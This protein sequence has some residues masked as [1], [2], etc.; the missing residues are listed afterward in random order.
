M[1]FPIPSIR[2][3]IETIQYWKTWRNEQ[4]KQFY[5][6]AWHNVNLKL[7]YKTL[8]EYYSDLEEY[9]FSY[10]QPDGNRLKMPLYVDK[11]WDQITRSTLEMKFENKTQIFNPANSQTEFWNFYNKLKNNQL[12]DSKIFRL[13]DIQTR[14]NGVCLHFELGSFEHSVMCQYILEHEI[15]TLLAQD[16]TPSFDK[17]KLRNEVA[18]DYNKI[19]YFFKNNV[20]RI[21]LNN[22]ILLK[23]DSKNYLP[24]VQKRSTISM[25]QQCLFDQISSCIFEVATTPKADFNLQHTILRE[26]YEEL[27]NNPD[28]A[29]ST[30]RLDPSF[31]YEHDGIKD[32]KT[33]LMNKDAIFDVTGF[34][35]DLVRIVPEITTVLIVRNENYFKKHYK[36]NDSNIVP[37]Q[38]NE[39]F[40]LGSLFEIPVDLDDVDEFLRSE[41][42]ADPDS[43]S[44]KKGFNPVNWTLPGG[45]SFYQG[46]KRA[47]QKN[48]L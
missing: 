24:M 33:L 31:F 22:L 38:L 15:V 5:W 36:T 12:F 45:F 29:K 23:K 21:G 2:D 48:L 40:E 35:I 13:I 11:G 43:N 27:Y 7:L 37:F 39:E 19:K 1:T 6:D 25:L 3:I 28:V 8:I 16:N 10:P 20:G 42:V 4:K 34:C 14:N 9:L 41:V 17:F 44:N 46:L 18:S 30:K 47:V 32:L 26:I